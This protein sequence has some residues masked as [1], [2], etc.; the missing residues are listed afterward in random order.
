MRAK[1]HTHT[2]T[3][4]MMQ[5]KLQVLDGRHTQQRRAKIHQIRQR[6]VDE[7]GRIVRKHVVKDA[8][9]LVLGQQLCAGSDESDDSESEIGATKQVFRP[10]SYIFL[11]TW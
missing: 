4:L 9:P 5:E 1:S 7:E 10:C 3:D 2:H 6:E 11:E 8:H